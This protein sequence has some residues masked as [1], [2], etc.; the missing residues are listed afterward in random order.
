MQLFQDGKF[1][2]FGPCASVPPGIERRC[3]RIEG[4]KAALLRAQLR[5]L[6]P[7]RPG[8]Y[9]ML[10]GDEQLIYVGKAKNLRVRL[11]SYFRRKGRPPKAGRIIGQ[12]RSIVWEVLPSEFASLLRELELIRRW[13]PRWNVQGQPLRRRLT[14]LCLGRAPAPYLFLSR[15][16]TARVQSAFGPLTASQ[17]ALDACRRLNDFFQLRDCP[18]PQEMIFPDVPELFPGERDPGCLR[19][20]IGTCLGPCTGTCTRRDYHAQV[21]RARDFLAGN[22]LTPLQQLQ[23]QMQAAAVACQFERAAALR[24]RLTVLQWLADRLARIRKAQA[25]MSFIYPVASWDGTTTWHLIHGAR[26]IASIL[27]PHDAASRKAAKEQIDAIY[28]NR[29]GLLDS[30]EHA[31]SM[32]VVMQWFRKYPGEREKCIS[33]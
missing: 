19:L 14:F 25:E 2:D 23:N 26:T 1:V 16:I 20:E 6:A 7:T 21:R 11:Q 22:D 17:N 8:V 5:L 10:D 15:T 4:A 9:G 24:D 30:Y 33:V 32:M 13:R 18:Q 28:R 31:D 27:K 12:A 29:S 3:A